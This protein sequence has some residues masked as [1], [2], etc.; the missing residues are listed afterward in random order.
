MRPTSPRG[1]RPLA[2][3][4]LAAA[5]A[6]GIAPASATAAQTAPAELQT[7]SAIAADALVDAAAAQPTPAPAG[8]A[9][10][11]APP[12]SPPVNTEAAPPPQRV[13]R[14][15]KRRFEHLEIAP[16]LQYTISSGGD[17]IPQNGTKPNTLPFDLLRITG[18]ARWRFNSHLGL[19]YQRIAHTG[20][21]GRT[22]KNGK[23]NYGGS[24]YDYEERELAVWQFDPYLAYRA[25]YH[26]RA[27]VCCPGAGD[28]T[29]IPRFLGGFFTDLSYRFGPNTIGG[30]PITTSFRWEQNYHRF[31]AA[32]QKNLTRGDYDSGQKPT[33]AYTLYSNFYFY[34]QTKLVPYYGI[35]YFSTYFSNNPHMS[36]TYRKV[37]GVAYRAGSD[38]T[39][40]FY[41]KN[42][43]PNGLAAGPDASHKSTAFLEAT[44]RFHR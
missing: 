30:K 12:A 4:A 10:P 36:E 44:Y 21:A 18:D 33:F 41:V 43:Q 23:P 42:D 40:R 3:A 1:C 35:E 37:Y 31:T 15:P 13:P 24:G 8:T 38:L 5:L 26:Y 34:H 22:F 32:A 25:G 2:A 14:G 6:L 17:V 20:S 28:P 7:T 39:W 29:G 11:G 27:R 19:M 9:A 16:T